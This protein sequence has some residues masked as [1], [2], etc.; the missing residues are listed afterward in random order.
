MVEEVGECL[1]TGS[2]SM[3]VSEEIDSLTICYPRYCQ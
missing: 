3:V 2:V 1:V